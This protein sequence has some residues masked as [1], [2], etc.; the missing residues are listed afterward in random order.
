MSSK[1]EIHEGTFPNGLAYLKFGS[2]APLVAL[3]GS[4]SEHG[5]LSGGARKFMIKPFL[6]LGERHTVYVVN[7]RPGLAAG[8]T[9]ADIATDLAEGLA[10][11]FGEPVDVLGYS[12]GGSVAQQLALGHPKVVRRLVVTSSAYTLSPAGRAAMRRFAELAAAGKRPA[13]AWASIASTS[14]I[15]Q[16]LWGGLL[17][18]LDPMM[19]PSD[20][21]YTDGIRAIEAEDQWDIQARL[22]EIQAPTLILGG[23]KDLA[24]PA[25]MFRDTAAGIP[26]AT[27]VL[28][29]GRDHNSAIADKRFP[30]TVAEF[31]RA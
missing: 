11:E 8:S 7:R 13:T 28:Y 6:A 23:D 4:T 14:P 21:D 2:G 29:E 17:W 16:R 26:D 5:N 25:Q 24:Y 3:P 31:L 15:G 22:A 20:G 27:L 9:L 1:V 10:G 30:E 19:R 12:T 18:L